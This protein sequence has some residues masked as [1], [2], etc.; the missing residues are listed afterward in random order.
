MNH[1]LYNI[2]LIFI[3]LGIILV[4]SY[5]TK[6]TNQC[7]SYINKPKII[8]SLDHGSWDWAVA[9]RTDRIVTSS[10]SCA[11]PG[12]RCAA[13]VIPSRHPTSS[14][15]AGMRSTSWSTVSTPDKVDELRFADGYCEVKAFLKKIGKNPSKASYWSKKAQR[16]RSWTEADL[17]QK[18][19]AWR[20]LLAASREQ[21]QE[22]CPSGWLAKGP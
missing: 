8:Y 20:C 18:R 16:R 11:P 7:P 22:A 21:G 19:E 15:R 4:T 3:L 14:T 9:D 10:S 13:T 5:M 1:I 2:S 6:A 17:M 12:S